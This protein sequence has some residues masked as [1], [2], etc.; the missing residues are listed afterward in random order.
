MNTQALDE[1]MA[2]VRKRT[3]YSYTWSTEDCADG[4]RL[5]NLRDVTTRPDHPQILI[6]GTY[7]SAMKMELSLREVYGR[8]RHLH[9]TSEEELRL[10]RALRD[11][12]TT[13]AMQSP[14]ALDGVL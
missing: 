3:G 9:L 10:G 11:A 6:F 1:L 8:V 2:I 12:P 4:E 5:L 7:P 13:D 14:F